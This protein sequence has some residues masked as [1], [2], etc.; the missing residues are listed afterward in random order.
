M[1]TKK[2][3]SYGTM[4]RSIEKAKQKNKHT[5]PS[6]KQSRASLLSL[7]KDV[8]EEVSDMK[9]L[10][11]N[12]NYARE[13]RIMSKKLKDLGFTSTMVDG[14]T[15]TNRSQLASTLLKAIK[16]SE[17]AKMIKSMEKQIGTK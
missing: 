2:S 15:G 11:P 13:I 14:K 9:E 12:H 10:R 7:A 6:Q 4:A 16:G 5:A 1:E 3:R 8:V 17:T